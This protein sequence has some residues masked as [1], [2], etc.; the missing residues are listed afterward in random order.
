MKKINLLLLKYLFFFSFVSVLDNTSTTV[1][2]STCVQDVQEQSHCK[3]LEVLSARLLSKDGTKWKIVTQKNFGRHG[4]QNILREQQGPTC[5]PRS[6]IEIGNTLSAFR[7]HID[8]SIIKHIQ[9]CTEIEARLKSKNDSWTI[10][11]EEVYETI[12]II[13]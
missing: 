9:K 3:F 1:T 11:F 6:K 13:I 12:A 2:D 7:L 5:L 10:S 8:D 4:I